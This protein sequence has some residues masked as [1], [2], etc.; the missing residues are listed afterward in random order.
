MKRVLVTVRKVNEAE[1]LWQEEMDADSSYF[2]DFRNKMQVD[3]DKGCSITI[4]SLDGGSAE[5]LG[6]LAHTYWPERS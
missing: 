6:R 4:R 2:Q 3:L 5:V 1:P